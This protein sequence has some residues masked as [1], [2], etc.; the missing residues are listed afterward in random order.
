MQ[1]ALD[2]GEGKA[3]RLP[4]NRVLPGSCGQLLELRAQ[5]ALRWWGGQQLT[6]YR[7][8]VMRP[9]LMYRGVLRAAHVT[10]VRYLGGG[11]TLEDTSPAR[12]AHLVR[13]GEA[14]QSACPAGTLAA[15]RCEVAQQPEQSLA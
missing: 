14:R 7:E 4:G 2:R 13:I 6:H 3:H 12:E 10:S 15:D 8:A 11:R 9:T 1:P 5:L